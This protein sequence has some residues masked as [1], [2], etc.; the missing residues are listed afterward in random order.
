MGQCLL[1]LLGCLLLCSALLPAYGATN[2]A[3]SAPRL[4]FGVLP[5]QSPV[6]QLKHFAPLRNYLARQLN[7]T[8]DITIAKDYAQHVA[9]LRHRRY[10]F[11]FTAPHIVLFASEQTPYSPVATFDKPLAAVIVVAAK[12]RFREL[13]DLAGATIATPSEKAIVTMV[14]KEHLAQHGLDGITSPHYEAFQTH[15]AAYKAVLGGQAEAAIIS[16]FFYTKASAKDGVLRLLSQSPSFPGIGI[17]IA[18]DLSPQLQGR[19][20]DAFLQLDDSQQGGRVLK[21]LG[22]PAY[23]A[24]DKE[25]FEPL[26]PFLSTL[27]TT[28]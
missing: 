16:R 19:I 9:D 26:R 18:D 4:S 2:K 25:H 27:M 14:G 11:V 3:I 7:K 5:S 22:F 10:D 12:S 17:L 1:R 13:K 24:A 15:N 21:Q 8:I 20:R 23:C 6:T 28:P